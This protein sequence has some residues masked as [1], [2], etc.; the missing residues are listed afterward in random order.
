MP[1]CSS[2]SLRGKVIVQCGASGQLGRALVSALSAADATLIIASRNRPL[3]ET[4]AAGVRASGRIIDAE[5]V[6]V[7]AEASI[8]MLR[9]RTLAKHQRIDGLVYNSV[10]RPMRAFGDDLSAWETSMATNA[11]GLFA[12]VRIFGD[13][14]A[15]QRTGSIVNIASIQGMVGS[16]PYLYEGTDMTAPPDYFFHKGGMLNLT[17]AL[18]SH[19]G[20]LGVRVNAVSPGGIY[21]SEHPQA[22]EFLRRYGQMTMLGR[23]A[24]AREIS[25]AVVFLLS[26]AA[27]YI[28]GINLPVDG[29]Y[30]AK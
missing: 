6:D 3:L 22:P 21:N 5:S 29:G 30:T 24:E 15:S 26:D 20:S 8:R 9:D 14:M 2:F 7:T 17:R 23:L 19:Y 1:E 25:G 11:T 4:I 18:A 16:N 12:A 27:S 10:S 13:V 28:T